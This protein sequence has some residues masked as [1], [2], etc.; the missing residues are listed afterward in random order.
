MS[1]AA[2]GPALPAVAA[3]IIAASGWRRW[4]LAFAA[5]AT[6]ALAL[7]PF[8]FIPALLVPMTAAAWLI[9]GS[10]EKG[11]KR[12]FLW[13]CS[14]LPRGIFRAFSAGWWWGFGY[15]AAGLWW[16]GAAFLVEAKEFAWALPLGVAGL[17][18]VLAIF[19][20]LGFAFARLIW[21]PGAGRLF[22]L[23]AGLSFAEWLRGHFFTG[24]PWNLF[25]MA[26]GGTLITAQSASV[27]G[28][29]G[30]TIVA[31]LIFSSPALLVSKT[32][33]RLAFAR[34]PLPIVAAVL[35]FGA[36]CIFGAIRLSALPAPQVP[37]VK[38]RIMQPNV[39][40]DEKFRPERGP[41][42]LAH[43]LALSRRGPGAKPAGLEGVTL[44]VWPESAFPFLLSRS[45]WALEEIGAALPQGTVL[46]TGAARGEETAR[47]AGHRRYLNSIQ[48]VASGGY[49]LA[50]YDKMHLVPFGEYLPLRPLF[51]LLHM[52]EFVH[53]PGGFEAGSGPRRL[54][55]TGMPLAVP[56][57]C[58]EAI[59]SGEIVPPSVPGERAGMLLNVTNDGW[60]G[61][62]PGPYQHFAQARLRA[63][64]EGL[65][66]IRAA[67]TG[68]SAIVDP[69]GRIVARLPLGA[70]GVLDGTLLQPADPPPFA[71]FPLAIVSALWTLVLVAAL[72]A[73]FGGWVRGFLLDAAWIR[74]K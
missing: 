2:K 56:L 59:F 29:Y 41:E 5:G 73:K 19:P 21:S 48:A 61:A 10:S 11:Q 18:A 47:G 64:E 30:L 33:A 26:L 35:A 50:T 58:Y 67:N 74:D 49:I 17:P 9:D 51:D 24:F 54:S 13:A 72:T 8:D 68:I 4:L 60:F 6:G 12:H 25:G 38:L 32:P 1:F 43:Y 22:A 69:L 14:G 20:G 31:I 71:R 45:A 55:I 42:I 46:V 44:L 36:N 16:L 40:Q 52:R 65:P 53:V 70:E 28:V 63:I 7:A 3:T 23:A 37:G 39:P 57:I 66:L 27:I 62:T 15:F 34:V